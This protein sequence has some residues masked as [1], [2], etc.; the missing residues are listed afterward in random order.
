MHEPHHHE[1]IATT[2][3]RATCLIIILLSHNFIYSIDN[4]QNVNSVKTSHTTQHISICHRQGQHK[5]KVSS[6]LLS[7]PAAFAHIDHNDNSN[8]MLAKGLDVTVAIEDHGH[9]VDA[10]VQHDKSGRPYIRSG[11][12]V[13]WWWVRVRELQLCEEELVASQAEI[14]ASQAE[15]LA[16][17]AES[18]GLS[19]RVNNFV[20]VILRCYANW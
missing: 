3:D 7:I 2:S 13:L 16:S 17:Q 5:M 15:L 9:H 19:G 6:L 1:R 8:H 4:R 12:R 11:E 18:H 14:I 10:I 20:S